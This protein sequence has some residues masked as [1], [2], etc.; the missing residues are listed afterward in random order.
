MNFTNHEY[1]VEVYPDFLNF[2][3]LKGWFA[4]VLSFR[5]GHNP[6]RLN[7]KDI[8]EISVQTRD[9]KQNEWQNSGP[10]LG[11]VLKIL[12]AFDS[13]NRKFTEGD[14][15]LFKTKDKQ[16]SIRLWE[17]S[18][19][20]KIELLNSIRKYAPSIHLD[21]SIQ[22]ALVGSTILKQPQYTEIWFS[23][24]AGNESAARG[25]LP[26]N[27]SLHNG[28]YEVESCITSGGQAVVYRAKQP[29]GSSVILKEFQLT[30][31]ES[32]DAKIESAK[33]FE[34]E[35]TILALLKHPSIV[36]ILDFFYEKGRVYL[37]LED[38]PGKTLR[39]YVMDSGK[40]SPEEVISIGKKMCSILEYLHGQ[41]PPVVHRDFT[42]ENIILQPNG[43]LKLI[44]FSIAENNEHREIG[45]CAGKHSYTPPE[46]FRG[47]ACPAS[48]IYAMGATMYFL[49]TGEDPQAITTS[50]LTGTDVPQKLIDIVK[51][52]TALEISGRYESV[53]WLLTDLQ[54]IQEYDVSNTSN[55][56][57]SSAAC[58]TYPEGEK[59]DLGTEDSDLEKVML[60]SNS[61]PG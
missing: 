34:N 21:E 57:E 14:Y 11:L 17:L 61:Q 18:A 44:D 6:T 27:S 4:D 10:G 48:D 41:S 36:E 2:L 33:A 1:D 37:V 58:I 42:P 52:A 38:I 46:Q 55:D 31:G 12:K 32:L 59:I 51:E 30:Q 5:M 50:D 15:L 53:S 9:L 60:I 8:I 47:E 7:W 35:S 22:Q 23:I 39:Q 26:A 16:C 24:L 40:L 19:V 56:S 3:P 45:E 43:E 20:Q 25:D 29:D 28:A 54:A 49:V 13:I